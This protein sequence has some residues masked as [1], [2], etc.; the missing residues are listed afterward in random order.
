MIADLH[1]HY[2]MHLLPRDHHPHGVAGG[3]LQ[4]L[5]DE[6]A[7]GGNRERDDHVAGPAMRSSRLANRFPEKEDAQREPVDPAALVA[8]GA[9]LG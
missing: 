7:R 5:K 1:C 3:W 9:A 6:F 8:S 2:P 4:K